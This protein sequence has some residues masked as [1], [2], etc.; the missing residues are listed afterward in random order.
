MHDPPVTGDALPVN[1]HGPGSDGATADPA[2]NLRAGIF[3][4]H[5]CDSTSSAIR[6]PGIWEWMP[7]GSLANYFLSK[8]LDALS[9]RA[10][11]IMGGNT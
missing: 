7:N 4:A 6:G 2:A 5:S 10:H 1:C 11:H 3:L 9:R 8:C